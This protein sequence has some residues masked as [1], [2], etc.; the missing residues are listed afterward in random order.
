MIVGDLE[1]IVDVVELERDYLGLLVGLV[2]LVWA[3]GAGFSSMRAE[4]KVRAD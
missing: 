1:E 3:V 4:R 2:S